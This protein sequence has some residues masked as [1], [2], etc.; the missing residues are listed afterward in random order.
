MRLSNI[1]KVEIVNKQEKFKIIAIDDEIGIIK[2][3]RVILEKYGYEFEGYTDHAEG[4][5]EIKKNHYDLLILDYLLN[6]ING[7]Q[8]VEII[9]E[10]DKEL[11]ILFLTGHSESAP[12]LETLEKNDIQGY[13]SKSNDQ[14]QLLL[15]VKS[16]YKVV[17]MMNEIRLTRNGLNSILESV[18][19][20][21]Q[22]QPIDGILEEVLR[23]LLKI[24][25][26]NNAFIFADNIFGDEGISMESF[27]KG[28]GKF[29][30]D[31]N[32]FTRM[33]NPSLMVYAGS[34]RMQKQKVRYEEGVFFPLINDKSECMGVIYVELSDDKNISLLDIFAKHAAS[35][36]NNAFMHSLL[37]IK[38]DELNKTYEIIKAGYEE[39]IDTLRLT[40]DA[41]DD[42]TSGHSDRVSKY[43]VEIGKSF[44]HLNEKDVDL[45][46]VAGIF[47]DIGKIGTADDI[48][49]SGK[50][51][52]KLEFEEIRKH[53]LTGA[54]ILSALSMF[55]DIVPLVMFHHERVDGK[56]Y[57]N[58]L[59]GDEIPFLAKILAIADSFDAMTTNRLYRK[60]LSLNDAIAQLMKGSGSQFDPIVVD[61]FIGL[62]KSGVV[63]LDELQVSQK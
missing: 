16:A 38:N 58:C 56:G 13:C 1:K 20:I 62:L 35:S 59:K 49:L 18:P 60:K 17:A 22:L 47:H 54:N 44:E 23:N 55:K 61:K 57:P 28:I 10:F 12:P 39:T 29:D 37:N 11:Y 3:L 25:K 6:N 27:F 34:A 33:F 46:R 40:V 14:S 21:Y 15:L 9:R 24:V 52:S 45:L 51:L 2:T 48:L 32:T 63:K 5:E 36:I 41:K 31:V 50:K 42:Y 30:T 26:S 43:A 53:P 8:V 7:T 4:I 19:K